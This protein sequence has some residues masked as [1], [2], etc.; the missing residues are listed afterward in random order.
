MRLRDATD[1]GEAETGAR[2]PG[3]EERLGDARSKLLGNAVT[4]VDDLDVHAIVLSD[5]GADADGPAPTRRRERI[6]HEVE[7]RLAEENRIGEHRRE[8]SV[9]DDVGQ[10]DRALPHAFDRARDDRCL[11]YT[12]DAADEL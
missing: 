4:V 3:G 11:L 5:V 8:I 2:R 9:D 6:R 12:S 1:E 7:D 10:L